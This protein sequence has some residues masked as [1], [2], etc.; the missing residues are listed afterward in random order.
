MHEESEFGVCAHWRYKGTDKKSGSN[1]YE[2][3]ISWL[4][5]VLDWHEEMGSSSGD[6][7]EHFSATQDRV[8]VFTPD[9]HVVNLAQGSTPLDFAYHVH[10]EVGHRCRGAKVGGRIV[11]L[12]Y[13]LKTGEQVEILTGKENE[14][15]RDWLQPTLS[16]LMSSRARAKVK[17]WFKQQDQEENID[18]GRALLDKIFKRVALNSLDYKAIAKRFGY[19]AVEDM[20][21]AV[22][23]GD[24][25]SPQVLNAAQY[26]LKPNEDKA[27][28][29]LK[30]VK[31]TQNSSGV[32]I[33]GVGN[34]MTH[35]AL[36]CKPV[37]GDNIK[38][39]IT[40]ARG[41]SVH[42]EDCEKLL[43]L[44]HYEPLR[45]VSVDW[46]SRLESVYPVDIALEAFDR[47]GLLRDISTLMANEKVDVLSM[48]TL[49]DKNENTAVMK[50][51]VEI[52]GLEPLGRLLARLSRLPNV[53]NVKRVLEDS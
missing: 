52:Q 47:R 34:L 5:Q 6:V 15:R 27:G 46:D 36:C 44:Q 18:A 48:N 14:P 8:Y 42:R 33:R 31:P 13:T 50:L 20:Y 19:Q 3:K 11:P 22:G 35:F 39:Y 1:S 4:R 12:T 7:I 30:N 43:H 24:I 45:V 37:P 40:L 26:L 32:N 2:D 41:V 25:S 28:A 23:S 53:L 16:Y 49:T 51:T 29:A 21:A 9:G 17:Q 10:T 38:G